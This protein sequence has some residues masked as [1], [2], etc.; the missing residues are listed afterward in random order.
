M[1]TV[2][3]VDFGSLDLSKLLDSMIIMNIQ[4]KLVSN[5]TEILFLQIQK[6]GF[7][8]HLKILLHFGGTCLEWFC[9]L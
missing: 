5:S 9:T 8:N 3:F 7:V 1:C 4:L 6:N 2:S